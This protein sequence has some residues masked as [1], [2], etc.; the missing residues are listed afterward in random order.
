MAREKVGRKGDFPPALDLKKQ[1]VGTV[2]DGYYIKE[3]TIKTPFGTNK[4]HAFSKDGKQFEVF[5][6][7]WLNNALAEVPKGVY[8][9]ITYKGL[10][11]KS[12]FG[13]KPHIVDVEIDKA[14]TLDSVE[15]DN[16]QGEEIPF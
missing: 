5:G 1:P 15:A 6:F 13:N 7:T 9:W 2:V 16:G 8:T 12:K 4:I 11:E 14:K 10:G 3:K